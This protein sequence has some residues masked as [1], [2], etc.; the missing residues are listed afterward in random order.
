[1]EKMHSSAPV[2]GFGKGIRR[3][4]GMASRN[5]HT[6][7]GTEENIVVRNVEICAFLDGGDDLVWPQT[8][9]QQRF[10]NSNKCR[11]AI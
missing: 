4:D 8:M 5:V 11:G 7:K 6:V 1:M 3:C 2:M 10:K 9:H